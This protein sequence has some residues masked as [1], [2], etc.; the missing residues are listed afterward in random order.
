MSETSSGGEIQE[1]KFL[2]SELGTAIRC[3]R[4]GTYTQKQ[5]AA[6]LT[7]LLGKQIDQPM[8]ARIEN[9]QRRISGA[10]LIAI[11]FAIECE[12]NQVVALAYYLDLVK[13]RKQGI[14]RILPE[15]SPTDDENITALRSAIS[16]LLEGVGEE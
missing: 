7:R 2:N 3:L 16:A 5:L 14:Q 12:V 10:L 1:L 15:P 8:V 4:Q 13:R 11:C 6:R 9:N